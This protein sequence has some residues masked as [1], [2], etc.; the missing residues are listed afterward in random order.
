MEAS[1]D[2]ALRLISSATRHSLAPGSPRH[3]VSFSVDMHDRLE[4]IARVEQR[5]TEQER[6]I[7]HLRRGAAQDAAV[8]EYARE[9]AARNADLT[10]AC[11]ALKE[12]NVALT[13][14]HEVAEKRQEG[15]SADVAKTLQSLRAQLEEERARTAAAAASAARA[16]ERADEAEKQRAAADAR[17]ASLEQQVQVFCRRISEL[18]AERE[19]ATA[20]RQRIR[21]HE[22]TLEGHRGILQDLESA[23][24]ATTDAD[25]EVERLKAAVS[26]RMR[27]ASDAREERDRAVRS[28]ADAKDQLA[29]ANAAAER[30]R[31]EIEEASRAA[32]LQAAAL[33]DRDEK[34]Q[35]LEQE[36]RAQS[37]GTEESQVDSAH[38]D[39]ALNEC[40]NA[41]LSF[42]ERVRALTSLL[43]SSYDAAT[44]A[45]EDS[46]S[47]ESGISDPIARTQR[48]RRRAFAALRDLSQVLYD[49]RESTEISES[50]GHELADKLQGR[51]LRLQAS[52]ESAKER[53]NRAEGAARDAQAQ[54]TRIES[55]RRTEIAGMERSMQHAKGLLQELEDKRISDDRMLRH[56]TN[57]VMRQ[58][59]LI[60]EL[61]G[62]IEHLESLL[63]LRASPTKYKLGGATKALQ[64]EESYTRGAAE[65]RVIGYV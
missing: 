63:Q 4:G 54:C 50:R 62:R 5:V 11:R 46:A 52:L 17:R 32:F 43:S 51:V 10:A 64:K 28:G 49:K 65:E 35:R 53:A 33:A 47:G 21:E 13:Q 26:D 20:L 23:R 41:F 38:K 31:G 27:E 57:V 59:A 6:I 7:A 30:L 15:W 58:T 36:A 24:K 1:A 12:R 60:T 61:D 29:A 18:E 3:A 25:R 42:T 37:A 16:K 19:S 2:E 22:R 56:S 45:Q 44:D 14:L 39:E 48:G 8:R 34:L 55:A 40:G 9:L